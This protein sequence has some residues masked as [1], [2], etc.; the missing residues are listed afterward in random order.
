MQYLPHMADLMIACKRSKITQAL[1]G[2]LIG[3][4]TLFK[5]LITFLST[6]TLKDLI[7]VIRNLQLYMN[8]FQHAQLYFQEPISKSILHPAIRLMAST[9]I[10]FPSG[11]T[12]RSLLA[13]RLID[14]LYILGMRLGHL[15]SR[16]LQRFFVAFDKLR[17]SEGDESGNSTKY[18]LYHLS[19]SIA[20]LL[21]RI[22]S[23]F[24]PPG[25]TS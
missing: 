25:T 15:I 22:H 19:S 21:T 23:F 7:Q 14:C 4:I 9:K 12:A 13:S 18:G 11:S 24:L 10:L 17:V 6:N 3:Y 1:E 16:S 5:Y 20:L 2:G 8:P